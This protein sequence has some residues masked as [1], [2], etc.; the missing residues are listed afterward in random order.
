M[1]RLSTFSFRVNDT[2]RNLIALLAK[3]L[4]RSQSDAI[5]FIILET[6]KSLEIQENENKSKY[7]V[8][9]EE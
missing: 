6:V 2:E 4:K 1:Q 8:T 9:N 3:C 5:R 7:E